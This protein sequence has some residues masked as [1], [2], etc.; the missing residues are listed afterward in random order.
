VSGR[1]R[2]VL[3][4]LVGLVLLP[5]ALEVLRVELR[6]VT[7][8]ELTAAVAGI[9]RRQLVLAIALTVLNYLVL[10]GYDQLAFVYIGKPLSRARI[11]AASFLAYAVANNVGLSALSGAS[12]RYRFYTRWGVTA[13]E[14]SRIVFSYSVTF[15]LGLLALGG[16]ALVAAPPPRASAPPAHHVLALA[17]WLLMLIP[18]AY[19]GL[20]VVRRTPLRLWRVELPMPSPRMAAAQF[21]LSCIEWSLA[22]AVLYVLLPP[23]PLSFVA[24]L[25]LFVSAILLGIA[26]HVPGGVGVFEGL[27]VLF[28]K[29]YL[30]SGQLLPALVVF[31]VVYYFLP[32]TVAV[33]GL[34][35]DEARQRRGQASRAGA[36]VG[37]VT[38][39]LTPRVLAIVTF[40]G[41]LMLLFSG[42]TPASG[43]RLAL[44]SR[45]VPLQ[46]IEASHFLASV[47]GTGLLLL[48]Q[49]LRRRLDGAYYLASALLVCGVTASMLKGFDYEEA[50][51]LLLVLAVL[52][53]ARPAFDRR[54]ALVEIPLS[55]TGVAAVVLAIGASI[56][57]GLFAFR[58][59]EYS[60][61]LWWQF[62]LHGDASRFLRASVGAAVMLLL[63]G[64]ARLIGYAPH[65]T[66]APT[67]A[68]LRDAEKAIA[69]QTQTFPNLAFLKDKA[70][71]FDEAR[72]AFVMYAVQGRTWVALG[73][74]V[75]PEDRGAGLVRLF[76]ERCADFGGVPVFYEV[77]GRQLHRY[78][79]F[80]LAFVK[81]GEEALVDLTAF[82]LEGPEAAKHRKAL[83]R[84]ER[85]GG[86]FRVVDAR[87]VPAILSALRAVSDDWLAAKAVA[88]KGFSLGFF[89]EEYLSRFPVAVIE[90][91]GRIEAFANLWPGPQRV[92]VSADLMR[93]HRDAPKDVM[94]ALFVH[95]LQ[96]SKEQGYHW[97]ALGMAPLSGF[98]Q[99]PVAPLWNRIGAFLYEHGDPVYNFHGLRAYKEKFN[100]IWEPHYLAYPGGLRLPRILADVSALVAGGYRQIFLK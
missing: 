77:T 12:V 76:L 95:I 20:T 65:A 58:H 47:A 39:Q 30:T 43:A 38:E 84:L 26:S 24:F 68:D 52:W 86:V 99:S 80:G 96:W 31:R 79:D 62:E 41:G 5:V 45:F 1:A 71:L 21:A 91:E 83:R 22:G 100:P 97:F 28:L 32:L 75:G 93:Y 3:P 36:L 18:L 63:F 35:I 51:L 14:L 60:R 15:W 66:P 50:T 7:W 11:A 55:P 19:V 25:G 57:L 6:T 10:T 16:L 9:P 53:R 67:P 44:L 74:P 94:E 8:P 56:W 48:A 61:D 81:L 98:E 64:L 70:L 49:G 87:G 59:V 17:G 73:D 23:S 2:R 85:D 40:I 89:D 88:E 72:S 82:T 92:G 46:V 13:E 42:A 27:M 78:A 29:P 37:R 33:I 54:A 90:R 69:A 34:G 4:A